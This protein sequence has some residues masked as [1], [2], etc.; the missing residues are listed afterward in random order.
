M[1]QLAVVLTDIFLGFGSCTHRAGLAISGHF[2]TITS[3]SEAKSGSS[4]PVD[5][6]PATTSVGL[7]TWFQSVDI[8]ITADQHFRVVLELLIQMD[9]A[10]IVG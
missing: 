7:G 9:M 5:S 8:S 6:P 3:F 2:L 1:L 4:V 10:S